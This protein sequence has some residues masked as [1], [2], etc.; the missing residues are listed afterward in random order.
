MRK[1]W[2]KPEPQ[3]RIERPVQKKQGCKIRFKKTANGEEMIFSPECRPDQI[4]MA[5]RMREEQRE[6]EE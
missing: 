5:K 4:E 1:F 2:K 3:R 6:R